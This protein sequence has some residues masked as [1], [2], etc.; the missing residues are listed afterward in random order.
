MSRSSSTV[1]GFTLGEVMVV[2]VIAS[3]V[4]AML[5]SGLIALVRGLQPAAVK[6]GGET[7][8]MAPTIGSFPSAVRLH[9]TFSDRVSSARAVYVLG[10]RHLSIPAGEPVTQQL[11]L[12]LRGLPT[13]D[14]SAGLP[15]DA[16]GFYERYTAA[17]GEQ[18]DG[19]SA[20]DF[21]V[22][23]V[24]A[25]SGAL[26]VTCFVQSR[27]TTVSASD[28]EKM[29]P[30]VVR[31][32]CLWDVDGTTQ[33]YAFAERPASSAAIFVGAVHTWLRYGGHGAVSEEGPACLIFPDPW[34]YAGS[35]GRSDDLPPFSR[36][37]YFLAVS[38]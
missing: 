19:G 20:D 29:I 36:F 17:L 8:P 34:V 1:R 16:R 6:L 24:G 5:L 7:L 23:V 32:V 12:K 27:R 37:S 31:E 30:Y 13:I 10:G 25:E 18:A 4:I 15:M 38:P 3:L 9:Q 14:L 28:G 22:V 11:P 2:L 33:R 35:R 26:R 21:S